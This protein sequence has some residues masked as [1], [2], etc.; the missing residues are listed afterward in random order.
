M[1]AMDIHSLTHQKGDCFARENSTEL[2]FSGYTTT[3]VLR[4]SWT[5]LTI[6]VCSNNKNRTTLRSIPFHSRCKHRDIV[7]H[8]LL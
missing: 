6:L 1:E 8:I 2:N 5:L 3:D 4:K 7:V